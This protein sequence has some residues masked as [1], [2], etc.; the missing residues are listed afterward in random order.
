MTDDTIAILNTLVKVRIAPSE[1]EG[2]GLFA[3]RDIP[4]G[5]TLY[6]DMFPQGYKIPKE[7]IGKL[8]P[9]VKDILLGRW[10]QIINGSAF[11]YPDT[12]VQAYINH[13]DKPNYNAQKDIILKDVKK[14]EEITED[15]SLI[16]N[17][18]QVFPW[19]K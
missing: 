18:K 3:I 2:V 10:P 15:Y 5:E 6:A 13:S 16:S 7:S 4:K 12:R 19:L 11:M 9:E 17:Y 8:K 14:G 1:I